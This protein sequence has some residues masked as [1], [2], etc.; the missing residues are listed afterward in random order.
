MDACVFCDKIAAADYDYEADGIVT[1]VPLDPVTDGHLLFLPE[2][3]VADAGED[4]SLAGYT[5]AA[6]ADYARTLSSYN[7]VTSSGVPATQSIRHLHIHVI[8][9]REGDGLHLPWTGQVAA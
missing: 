8:P 7:I 6:A 3:H 5:M 4:P 2:R 9:R 1:F